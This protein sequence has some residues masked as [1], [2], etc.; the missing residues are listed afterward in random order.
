[1]SQPLSL[2]QILLKVCDLLD[3]LRIRG[4]LI[5]GLAVA[6][7]GSPRTTE[8]IDLL[9]EM[10]PSAEIDAAFRAEGWHPSWHHGGSEDP[11]PLLLRLKGGHGGPEIEVICA[12]RSWERAMLDRA[13]RVVLPDGSRVPVVA[14]ADL[15]VLKLLAGGP[16]DLVDVADL[17]RRCGAMPELEKRAAERGVLDLLR[18]VRETVETNQGSEQENE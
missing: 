14:P 11:I 3:R 12:T 18:R 10:T 9:A 1:M 4:A 6:T 7:W 17:L 5:G 8:D 13:I 15:I 2:E 16:Q